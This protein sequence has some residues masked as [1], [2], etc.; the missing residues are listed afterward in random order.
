MARSRLRPNLAA[1]ATADSQCTEDATT[2]TREPPITDDIRPSD[3]SATAFTRRDVLRQTTAAAAFSLFGGIPLARVAAAAGAPADGTPVASGAEL[4]PRDAL[5]VILDAVDRHPLVAL[6]EHH[7]LQ[8][9]H[10]LLTALLLHPALPNT[11]TDVVVEFGNARYQ[12]LADRFV[13]G[14]E[15]VANADL[16]R[17]WREAIG[18]ITEW[19]APVY[20]Q[21]FCTVRAVNWMRP[22]QRRLR[23]LLGDPPIEVERIRSAADASYVLSFL[24]RRDAHFAEVVER[25]V[26]AKGR[27]A[28]LIAGNEHLLRGVHATQQPD[29]PNA[30]SLL[31]Q[32]HPGALFVVDSFLLPPGPQTDPRVAR[33]QQRLA[34]WPRP[35]LASLTG[36]W[37]GATT[38]AMAGNLIHGSAGDAVNPTA[39]RYD[40]QADAVLWLGPGDALTASRA[41]PAIYQCGDY[42]ALLGRLGP[43]A[44]QFGGP[45]DLAA[46]ALRQAQLGPEYFAR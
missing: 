37:L 33:L 41:E 2:M 23:V 27:R 20:A 35:A 32:R 36:T 10:D 8:E 39:A 12:D 44:A 6:A 29:T 4:Q 42:A 5:A 7:Q 25:E 9:F 22:P 34:G 45:S 28:L 18:G 11:L 16:Q 30:G 21:F 14:D 40:A 24:A 13:L 31:A 43:I 3:G 19:D 38:E 17:I 1:T 46:Q 15:P 26:L